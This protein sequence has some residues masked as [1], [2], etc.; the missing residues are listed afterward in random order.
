MDTFQRYLEGGKD[1][2][3]DGLNGTTDGHLGLKNQEKGIFLVSSD[4]GQ[5]LLFSH[6][7]SS[8]AKLSPGFAQLIIS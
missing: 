1:S 7:Q 8:A 6:P 3:D 4:D 2:L 5:R